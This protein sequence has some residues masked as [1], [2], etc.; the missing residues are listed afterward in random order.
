MAREGEHMTLN[1]NKINLFLLTGL[2]LL[3]FSAC[4][5]SPMRARLDKNFV[6]N[7]ALEL[8][9]KGVNAM[10]AERVCISSH[11]AEM[12]EGDRRDKS[13]KE[14]DKAPLPAASPSLAREKDDPYSQD[15]DRAPAAVEAKE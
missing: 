1:I 2:S 3:S 5:S 11:R 14:R 13:L 7:C 8:I 9:E 10:E 12:I 4:S 6:Y 15:G